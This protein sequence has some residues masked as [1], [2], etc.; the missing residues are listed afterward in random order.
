MNID[1]DIWPP[2]IFSVG[3]ELCWCGCQSP[4]GG[5]VVSISEETRWKQGQQEKQYTC[6]WNL[7]DE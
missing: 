7:N 6:S 3:R 5:V 4:G 1:R 2:P